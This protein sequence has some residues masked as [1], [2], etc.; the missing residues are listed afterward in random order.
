MGCYKLETRCYI[1]EVVNMMYKYNLNHLHN[2]L[3]K[4]QPLQCISLNLQLGME[5]FNVCDCVPA[6]MLK[7]M[8]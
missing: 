4:Q 3:T 7:G 6:W 1:I 5:L 2:Y 8:L